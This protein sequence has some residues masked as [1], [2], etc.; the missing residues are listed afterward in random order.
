[1]RHFCCYLDR[2][3]LSRMLAM[4]ASL[5]RHCPSF[6]LHVLALDGACAELLRR[7][8]HPEIEV[9]DLA[10]VEAAVPALLEARANRSPVEYVF[11]L[12]PV[13]PLHL[14]ETGAADMVT[15][16]DSDLWFFSDPRA[17][18]D[19]IGTGSI[20]I[21]PHR[22]SAGLERRRKYGI[23]NVGWVT[24]R[25]DE[26]GLGC[27]RWWRD[28]CLDWC[29]DRVEDGR[30]A[31][32]GYL[33]DWPERFDN[34]VV[35]GNPGANLA[36]WNVAGV[37]IE[38]ATDGGPGMLIDGRPLVF[39]HFQGVREVARRLYDPKLRDYGLGPR[40]PVRARIYRP[41]VAELVEMERR[42]LTGFPGLYR[43]ARLPRLGRVRPLRLI[44]PM[45]RG[46]LLFAAGGRVW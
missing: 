7:L 22:F 32:Q 24:L 11:T 42:L 29:H 33:N 34:V 12:S 44:G 39:Y 4:H 5:R 13:W 31:D 2:N 38:P 16:L 10:T 46:E 21:V 9:T 37:R 23:Y 6:R 28:R 19:E 3:Y 35:I 30:F 26:A 1:M 27:L 36:P 18:F 8:D 14:L 45:L 15:L 40:G 41:Y 43:P 25:G 20:A 17:V